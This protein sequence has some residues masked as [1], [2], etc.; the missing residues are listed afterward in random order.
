MKPIR[1]AVLVAISAVIAAG[2]GALKVLGGEN[3]L[4]GTTVMVDEQEMTVTTSVKRVA[5]GKVTFIIRNSG[6]VV[7]ELVVLRSSGGAASLPVKH[8]KAVEDEKATIGEAEDLEPGKSTRLTL[9]LR[10]GRYILL[11]NVVGHYQ[12]GMRTSLLVG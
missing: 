3:R 12:L 4:L 5:P 11:C 9:N 2:V 10:P 1:I 6:S 8:F 7:H